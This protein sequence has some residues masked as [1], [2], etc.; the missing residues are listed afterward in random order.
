MR[1]RPEWASIITDEQTGAAAPF[2]K[3]DVGYRFQDFPRLY[4][5]DG[6]IHAVRN[7]TL[8]ETEGRRVAHAWFGSKLYLLV[9]EHPMYS[10]EI[11]YEEQIAEAEFFLLYQ[12]Y[13]RNRIRE[14]LND[15]AIEMNQVK[16]HD[17]V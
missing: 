8:F 11:D 7:Q 12:R 1:D 10:L 13:G 16:S 6:A 14:K 9:Q 15:L 5:M 4:Q 3:G 2:V 17:S